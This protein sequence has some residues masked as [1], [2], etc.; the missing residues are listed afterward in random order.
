MESRTFRVP[1]QENL[2]IADNQTR[3]YET[4]ARRMRRFLE[5]TAW[6]RF[7]TP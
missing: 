2:L 6:G 4:S 5:Y 7:L 3:H 1:N